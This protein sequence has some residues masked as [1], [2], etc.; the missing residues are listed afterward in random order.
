MVPIHGLEH[1]GAVFSGQPRIAQS[2]I[3]RRQQPADHRHQMRRELE[4]NLL[5][6]HLLGHLFDFR[7]VAMADHAVGGNRFGGLRQQHRLLGHASTA[8]GPRFGID[9]DAVG[10]D[11]SLLE[12]RQEGQQAGRGETS[13]CSHKRSFS[14]GRSMPFR[15]AID[16]TAAELSIVA[17]NLLGFLGVDL[18][19]LIE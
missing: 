8:G 10:F 2:G 9:D 5:T 12:E 6:R 7:G 1:G 13:R 16:G 19:P 14:D 4:L 11:Q 3:D 18:V 15:Q 17:L